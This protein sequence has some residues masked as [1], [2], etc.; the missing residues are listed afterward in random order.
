MVC[1]FCQKYRK[2]IKNSSWVF[3]L[4][5]RESLSPFIRKPEPISAQLSTASQLPTH[6][7]STWPLIEGA[8]EMRPLQV[9]SHKERWGEAS[10]C[11]QALCDKPGPPLDQFSIS[12]NGS[13]ARHRQERSHWSLCWN[14][15]SGTLSMM[16]VAR[17]V[18]CTQ[19]AICVYLYQIYVYLYQAVYSTS[20]NMERRQV[21]FCSFFPIDKTVQTSL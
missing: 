18:H 15:K 5:C 20:C 11:K 4:F 17:L 2:N 1:H 10:W 9:C 19:L 3:K 14:G 12:A 21:L 13:Y 7:G 16:Q 6:L 8:A